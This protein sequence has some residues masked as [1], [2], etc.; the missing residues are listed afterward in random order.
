M[1]A[2]NSPATRGASSCGALSSNWTSALPMTTASA[3]SATARAVAP[4]RIPKPTPT[5][6]PNVRLDSRDHV[7][8]GG[9]VEVSGTGHALQRDMV[10]KSARHPGD[11]GDPFVGRG[12]RDEEDQID[13]G[14]AQPL[15]ELA[16]SSGG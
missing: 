6:R 9:D 2:T 8:D 15:G 3:T 11:G 5:G 4:S 10:N 12:R 7:L 14:A 13:R 1:P 16:H